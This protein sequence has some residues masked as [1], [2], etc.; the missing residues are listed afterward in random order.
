MKHKTST[1]LL[2][3]VTVADTLLF[4]RHCRKAQNDF[5]NQIDRLID[6]HPIR[7]LSTRNT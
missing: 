2:F 7:T 5:L 3:I 6:W 4:S 1:T